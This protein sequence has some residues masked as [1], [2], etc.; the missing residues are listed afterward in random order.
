MSASYV[1]NKVRQWCGEV[2]V[3]TGIPFYD[4]VNVAVNPADPVWFTA[5]FVSEMHEGT[6]CRPNFVEM[7]FVSLVFVARPGT[8]DV[9]CITAVEAVI[10]AIMLKEDTKLSLINFEPVDEDSLG[11]A[12][13]DYRMSVAVNY[14][15]SL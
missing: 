8:G 15:L 10:P 12:D 3:A 7:G 13:K 14:R 5:A 2:A 6:F 9:A 1:R 4:T 11:S